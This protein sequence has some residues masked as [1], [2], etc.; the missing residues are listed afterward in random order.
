ML[1]KNIEILSGTL[2][3]NDEPIMKL[4]KCEFCEDSIYTDYTDYTDETSR[5][6]RLSEPTVGTIEMKIDRN[7]LLTLLYGRKV[8]NNWLK[9][10]GGVMTRKKGK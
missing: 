3:L 6:I 4:D 2:Y 1:P 7:F 5:D 8:T 9:M 10:H